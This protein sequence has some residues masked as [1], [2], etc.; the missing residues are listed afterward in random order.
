[1]KTRVFVSLGIVLVL[2]GAL[3]AMFGIVSADLSGGGL[4]D[5]EVYLYQGSIVVTTT[6]SAVLVDGNVLTSTIEI[7]GKRF[8]QGPA[9]ES[10]AVARVTNGYVV[11]DVT[12]FALSFGSDLFVSMILIERPLFDS[13]IAAACRI[14]LAIAL[15]CSGEVPQHPPT[16]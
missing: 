6:H 5:P 1:M 2:A 9:M 13:D 12:G 8:W 4:P 3:F 7:E 15:M 10:G 11:T 16:N 14:E